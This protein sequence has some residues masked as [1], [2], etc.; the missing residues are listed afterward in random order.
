MLVCLILGY[1]MPTTSSEPQ[2]VG[3]SGD[4][5]TLAI[6]CKYC[7]GS[8][9]GSCNSC[10]GKSCF[11]ATENGICSE[12]KFNSELIFQVV[13]QGTSFQ[14]QRA[15]A[16]VQVSVADVDRLRL[17]LETAANA[18]RSMEKGG[19]IKYFELELF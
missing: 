11:A 9:A 17:L 2:S 4:F 19:K 18:N 13:H 14:C 8:C 12:I 5:E 16:R 6:G 10:P 1:M 15:K 3:I 7:A